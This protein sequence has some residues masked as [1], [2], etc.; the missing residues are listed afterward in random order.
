MSSIVKNVAIVGAGPG[1]LATAIALR[2]QGINV[3]VYEQAQQFRPA[4]A[5]LGIMPNGF[6]SLEAIKPDLVKEIKSSGCC[7]T[8]STLR[9]SLGE[10]IRSS[11]TDRSFLD[12]YGH[13][14]VTVWWWNL[15]QIL[16]SFFP[17]ETIH[18]AHRCI[19]WQANQ[20]GV[21]IYFE[22][23]LNARADVLIG[24]DGIKSVVR[25]KLIANKQPRYLGSFCWRSVVKCEQNFIEPNELVFIKGNKQFM[26]LLN[27]GD[28]HISWITR[29]STSEYELSASAAE[30]KARVLNEIADWGEPIKAIVEATEAERILEGP[31]CDRPPLK[32][33]SKGRVTLLG[34]AAHPMGPAMGQGANTAFEDAC[35]LASCLAHSSSIEA[36]FTNYEK[37]RVECLEI[38]QTRS[39]EGEKRY[40]QKSTSE[41]QKSR[42]SEDF[43]DWLYNY[44]PNTQSS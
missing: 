22:N 21:E 24:A 15:Q 35:V 3:Q 28:G 27:L 41:R 7:V 8:Q 11:S 38:I 37:E 29:K 17:P 36:A 1:G 12:K 26:Y 25:K 18:L 44:Q 6:N 42:T 32:T 40:Y 20:N 9:N 31:I 5:G 13:S 14:L 39:A 19:D 2:K 16:A 43:K 23:G 30:T 10:K 4:G 34:D 33:W